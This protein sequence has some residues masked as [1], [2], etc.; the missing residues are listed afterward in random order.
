MLLKKGGSK[1]ISSLVSSVTHRRNWQRRWF[2]LD[3]LAGELRYYR[4]ATLLKLKGT[5]RLSE[6]SVIKVPDVVE[7]RGR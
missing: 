2:Q 5:L 6:L 3:I 7:L 1:G 4:D